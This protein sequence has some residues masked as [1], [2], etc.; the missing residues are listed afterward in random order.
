MKTIVY[1]SQ[2]PEG[3]PAW[4][5]T[6]LG[7]VRSWSED[8]G[9]A[10]R[11]YGDEIFERVPAW[12]RDKTA[13]YPQVATD[14]GRLRLARELLDE[15]YE[16]T[17]WLDADVL[18]FDPENFRINVE[19]GSAFGREVWVQ[20]DGKG[21][22]RAY[23]NVHN[24]VALFCRDDTFLDFYADACERIIGRANGGLPPQIVGTKL[25]TALHNIVGFQLIDAVAMASPPVVRDIAGGGG[26]AL[27]R[28]SRE[29]EAVPEAVNLCSSLEGAVTDGV[30]LD[31]ALM[32]AAVNRLLD[33]GAPVFQR[34]SQRV[35][36]K[37]RP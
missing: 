3:L 18:V 14:L 1:Q 35:F 11:F 2:R 16:R 24:A 9:F 7:S 33:D 4:L 29:L 22:L 19:T 5:E 15:G 10:Y 27:D 8:R 37:L 21:G 36:H 31:A 17:V 13:A 25:L 12:Y 32:A 20:A 30:N 6:C 34:V 26:A 28:L 23:R